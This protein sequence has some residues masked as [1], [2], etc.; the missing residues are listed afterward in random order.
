MPFV[1]GGKVAAAAFVVYRTDVNSFGLGGLGADVVAY[2]SLGS[3]Q[4]EVTPPPFPEKKKRRQ[5]HHAHRS[6]IISV[7]KA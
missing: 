4:T 3:P 1:L 7:L 2:R 6:A 5:T